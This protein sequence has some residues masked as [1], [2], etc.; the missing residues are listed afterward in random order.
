MQ[1]CC[2]Y[3][4]VF[5]YVSVCGHEHV[6]VPL[7]AGLT[8]ERPKG[9]TNSGGGGGNSLVIQWLRIYLPKQGT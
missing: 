1:G 7:C 9:L 6:R 5:L 8:Q 2:L 4:C 3:V